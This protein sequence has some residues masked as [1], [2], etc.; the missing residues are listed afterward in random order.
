MNFCRVT[1]TK[2]KQKHKK[3]L[4]ATFLKFDDDVHVILLLHFTSKSQRT[5]VKKEDE[6]PTSF[7]ELCYPQTQESPPI[8]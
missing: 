6:A 7:K 4:S 2:C 3:V 5:E 1:P 8:V